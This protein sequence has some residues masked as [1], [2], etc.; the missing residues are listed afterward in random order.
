MLSVPSWGFK[1]EER[2]PED[3]ARYP[4]AQGVWE[5]IGVCFCCS[6]GQQVSGYLPAGAPPRA[7]AKVV[8]Q[9]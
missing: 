7:G 5:R 4:C 2:P 1:D 8:S 9:A 3:V 6:L